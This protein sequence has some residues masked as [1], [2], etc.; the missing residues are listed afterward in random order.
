MKLDLSQKYKTSLTLKKINRLKMYVI[1]T[2]NK[3][4]KAHL[5]NYKALEKL[6]T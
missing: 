6:K 3:V 4:C 2:Y 5:Q 1:I